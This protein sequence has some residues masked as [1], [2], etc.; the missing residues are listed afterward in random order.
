MLTKAEKQLLVELSAAM[1]AA[2][3]DA[4]ICP[5]GAFADAKSRF[6]AAFDEWLPIIQKAVEN[7]RG[8]DD[9]RALGWELQRI[10][11]DSERW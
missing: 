6:Q 2:Y 5:E 11:F 1:R 7:A 10:A 9:L 4:A 8:M 3:D